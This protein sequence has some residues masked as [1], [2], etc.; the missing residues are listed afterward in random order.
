MRRK[1]LL[2]AGITVLSLSANAQFW[3]YTDPVKLPGNAN[4]DAEESI[5]VF[6]SDSSIIYFVR[7]FDKVNKGDAN[8]QDIWSAHW[9]ETG[10][11]NTIKSVKELNNKFNNAVLG[12]STDGKRMYLLNAYEGKKDLEKGVALSTYSGSSWGTPAKV[13][14]PNLNLEGQFYGFHVNEDENVIIISYNGPN[15]KGEEDLYLSVKNGESWSVPQHMGSAINSTGFEISP[16][17]SKSQDTL[18]FSSNGFG[19]EGDAD[20]FYSVK[21]GSWTQWS[22]PKNLGNRIN[23]VKFDAYF[24][25]TGKQ[26]Y[27]SSNRDTER[28]DIWMMNI[29]TPPPLLI[30]CS[31]SDATMYKG[32]DGSVSLTIEGGAPPFTYSWSNGMDSKDLLATGAGTYTVT[33]TDEVGQVQTTTCT[34]NE[35]PMPIDPVVVTTYPNPFFEHLFGY[36][37]NKLSGSRGEFKKFLKEIEDQLKAGREGITIRI[38]S[39]ASQVPTK[40]FDN[41]E[42]LAQTRAENMKYDLVDYFERD[43]GGK[44]NIVIAEALV[45]GPP[46]E[47]DSSNRDKYEPFQYVRLKTE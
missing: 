13:E 9:D 44:V 17:L 1:I 6:S 30:S 26:A 19:G 46:Y 16:Y 23:S 27:W 5:P 7:T 10:N 32:M 15:S 25:L 47:D 39:S 38:Y 24:I 35:P 45:Q 20:I 11:Y 3:D 42:K 40:S 37:K 8:D 2:L 28:A 31:A 22:A 29:L 4:S 14:I 34:V 18:Y 33:V 36:N 43:F 21:Q 12:V 41:N